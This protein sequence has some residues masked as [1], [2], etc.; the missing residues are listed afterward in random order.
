MV[1]PQTVVILPEMK[2]HCQ[3][4]TKMSIPLFICNLLLACMAVIA[5]LS[6]FFMASEFWAYLQ[7]TSLAVW[8]RNLF[9]YFTIYDAS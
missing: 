5:V 6:L 7:C 9:G 4:E 8:P 3:N 1:N 2:D